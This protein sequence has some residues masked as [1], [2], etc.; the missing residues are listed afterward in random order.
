VSAVRV[1]L[2]ALVLLALAPSVL[3]SPPG[4]Y[5]V[6]P[7]LVASST[8]WPGDLI[9]VSCRDYSGDEMARVSYGTCYMGDLYGVTVRA[10]GVGADCV[11]PWSVGQLGA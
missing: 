6:G 9:L 1:V 10:E 3:A 4:Q 11:N 8:R 2:L 7:C 5:E